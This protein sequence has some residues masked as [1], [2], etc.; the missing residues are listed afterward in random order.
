MITPK[1]WHVGLI[2]AF[3]VLDPY[4]ARF[5]SLG[6]RWFGT[7]SMP[8]FNLYSSKVS[9]LGHTDPVPCK[10]L[11][12][13]WGILSPLSSDKEDDPPATPTPKRL[14]RVSIRL[15]SKQTAEEGDPKL[16]SPTGKDLTLEEGVKSPHR[17]QDL[18]PQV[19]TCQNPQF[20]PHKVAASPKTS[21]TATVTVMATATFKVTVETTQPPSLC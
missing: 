9:L 21:T 7:H 15:P 11:L 10:P 17:T 16:P 13:D 2:C 3:S 20:L 14:K 19:L 1:A 18:S 5:V 12:Q 4:L 8:S 6:I